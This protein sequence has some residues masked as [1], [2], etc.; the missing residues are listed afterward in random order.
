MGVSSMFLPNLGLY[1]A[2]FL[3]KPGRDK[4]WSK[5]TYSSYSVLKCKAWL[6]G[7]SSKCRV[8]LTNLQYHY[9]LTGQSW[10]DLTPISEAEWGVPSDFNFR[11][12]SHCNINAVTSIHR[13]F[14]LPHQSSCLFFLKN[15]VLNWEQWYAINLSSRTASLLVVLLD[16]EFYPISFCS[17]LR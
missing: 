17:K 11:K 15:F 16:N 2:I 14:T 8:Q 1:S 12:I 4:T 10:S 6:S 3:T 9:W 13:F 7:D 5:K